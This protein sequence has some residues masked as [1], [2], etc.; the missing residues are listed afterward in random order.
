MNLLS[1][2]LD[3]IEFTDYDDFKANCKLK[4]PDKFNFA[5]DVIDEYVR[6]A[7]E[8]RAVL[9]CNDKGE[10][11]IITFGELALLSKKIASVLKANGINKGDVL[12]T[13]LNRRW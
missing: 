9:W 13:I 11:K 10:E 1:K 7:P 5:Y 2:F 12:M 6:L 4:V 3:R 8:K